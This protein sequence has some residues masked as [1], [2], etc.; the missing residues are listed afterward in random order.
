[1]P[2]PGKVATMS[3]TIMDA[4]CPEDLFGPLLGTR[5]D[6]LE[7]VRRRYREMARLA[8]PDFADPEDKA[9]AEDAFAQLPKIRDAAEKAIK[10]GTYG[11]RKPLTPVR[12]VVIRSRSRSYI[13]GDPF[14]SGDLA[15]LY[16]CTFGV[17]PGPALLKVTRNAA[18]NDL[19]R[20]EAETLRHLLS[21][22]KPDASG[23]FPLL[24]R[25]TDSFSFRDPGGS[26]A[27]QASVFGL[28]PGF[29]SLED[30]RNAYPEGIS[31]RHMAW[32][33]R[34]L[35]LALGYAHTRGI[36]HGAVLPSHVLIHPDHDLMLVDW[37][38][39]VRSTGGS[40]IPAISERYADWYPPEVLAKQAP[41][42]A[43]DIYMS[44]RCMAYLMDPDGI[45]LVGIP[46]RIRGFITSCLLKPVS[47][48]P[49]D[50]WKLRKEFTTLIE[51][52]WGPR[53]R[54]PFTMPPA[55]RYSPA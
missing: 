13:V 45:G 7:S 54:I 18:D 49:Q 3:S 11:Q 24:P 31:P 30:V 26:P 17:N 22:D 38:Y 16:H 35:L 51:Q 33:W 36:I 27:R 14:A 9:S 4:T 12:A 34:Q 23:F 8:H 47:Y 48:R 40:H 43:T 44:A 32:I 21:S 28:L 15:N 42:P 53:R 2:V 46:P 1:M 10:A 19:L 20:A 50:A 41:S 39:A 37:C 5:D 52:L 55:A 25:L 6:Q 29:Y